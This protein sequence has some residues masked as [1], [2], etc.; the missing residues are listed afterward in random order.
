MPQH[1]KNLRTEQR[2]S[3]LQRIIRASNT[4]PTGL[5]ATTV[6]ETNIIEDEKIYDNINDRKSANSNSEKSGRSR[7]HR[8]GSVNYEVGVRLTND[9]DHLRVS[10]FW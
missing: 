10:F 2:Q 7:R 3:S 6:E 4:K 1:K 8:R 5:P 9:K